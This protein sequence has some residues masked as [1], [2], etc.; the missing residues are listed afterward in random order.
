MISPNSSCLKGSAPRLES[1]YLGPK[2]R[3]K[4]RKTNKLVEQCTAPSRAPGTPN[5]KDI[6]KTGL[7]KQLV[8]QAHL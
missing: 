3:L 7:K 8:K 1:L 5:P 4:Q 2:L 6:H